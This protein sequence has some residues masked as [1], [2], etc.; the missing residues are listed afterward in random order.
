MG[1]SGLVTILFTD[2]VGSTDLAVEI[3]DGAADVL[4]REHFASLREAIADTGGTE[5]KTIGDAVMVAYSSAADAVSG[6]VRM[7]Q[8]VARHN[9]RSGN[10]R[11]EMRVG[12]SAGDATFEDGDYFGTPVVEA[13]RLCAAAKGGQVLMSD[14]VRMLAGTRSEITLVPLGEM[15]LKGLPGALAVCEA[16]WDQ[17]GA[18]AVPLPAFLET[19]PAFPFAG[20]AG[21]VDELVMTWKDVVDGDR[22]VV[23]VSGEPGIGKTRLVTEV[24]RRAHDQGATVLWG[25][26]D[27]ELGVPYEPW[28]EGLRHYVASVDPA[29]L[30][31]EVGSLGGELTRVVPELT[32]RVPGLAAPVETEAETERHRL[33]EAVTDLLTEIAQQSPVVLVLDDIHWADKPTLLLLRH[34][35]RAPRMR[36]LV[37]ATYRDTDLDRS[38]PLSGVLA[39][40]RREPGVERL[41]L[42]GLDISEV[43]DFVGGA[44]GHELDEAGMNLVRALHSETEGNPFFV[45]EVLRHL[46]ESGAIVQRE[47][48][49]TSD[50]TLADLGIPEGIREVVGRRLSR[51]SEAAN[52]ALAIGSVIAPQSHLRVVEAAG[53]P[54]GDELFDAL[55]EAER[56]SL[57]R[58]VP[59]TVGR[60]Q[61]AHALVRSSLYEE[62]STNRRVRIHWKIGEALAG[63]HDADAN[64]DAI[65]HHLGEGALAGDPV[66]A[67]E[68]GRRAGERATAELAFEAAAAHYE[69]ALGTLD[70]LDRPDPAL[71]CDLQLA[72]AEALGASGDDRR[73]TAALAAADTARAIDDGDRFAVAALAAT[74]RSGASSRIGLVD[75][76]LVALL[77]EA[78]ERIGDAP[79]GARAQLL[80]DL[81]GELQW[82]P[83]TERRMQLA[84]EAL[85]MARETR[86]PEALNRTFMKSW[87]LVDGSEPILPFAIRLNEEAM[88]VARETG[89]PVARFNAEVARTWYAAAMGDREAFD[90]GVGES[91][92][93]AESLRQPIARYTAMIL[94]TAHAMYGG[95]LDEAERLAFEMFAF[96][97]SASITEENLRGALGGALYAIRFAQGRIGELVSTIED[98]V[99]DQPG[100]PVWRVALSGALVESERVDEARP[101]FLWLAEQGCANVPPDVEF[102]VTICGLARESF[103]IRPERA[104]VED[105][106]E[107]LLPFAETMNFSGSSITD[108]NDLGL[109]MAAAVLGRDDA[110][111]RHFADL[112]ALCE[113]ARHPTYLARAHSDWA[114]V[115]DQRGDAARASEEAEI[116][117]ELAEPYGLTGPSGVTTRARALL[118]RR[119]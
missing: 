108:P 67:V 60:Y 30:R 41:D 12:V 54:T 22:R 37:L 74:V 94:E 3:G 68:F 106:Y 27:E 24:V 98:L 82:G 10:A 32:A 69:R 92:R 6:A 21:Q 48:R 2:L 72:F 101:H 14:L 36:L 78:L 113:R 56:A 50:E 51:L 103:L 100:A 9:Q 45:G 19:L 107:K 95:D 44:A 1:Q 8:A 7:Q 119:S 47:G 57:V 97:Q 81:A 64:L 42:Q 26:C 49:W 63:R 86:D 16:T 109:G 116:A 66:R 102:P 79:S 61:F 52:L 65:A 18:V 25:R 89:D 112:V 87:T 46:V 29:Q 13:S 23:L 99:R 117:L 4:R 34:V 88:A 38:H 39:D 28:V 93:L 58:E 84:S 35:L 55:D 73:F 105:L 111:D 40:L 70:L 53:G 43:E 85:A 115:L 59:G 5:V 96:G 80:G 90:A 20:R 17:G 33:F 104:I 77:E 62:L 75:E 110:A 114:R 91:V 118:G 31:R 15:E 76:P 11:I 71:R 83:E